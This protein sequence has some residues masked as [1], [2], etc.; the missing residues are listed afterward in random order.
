MPVPTWKHK[1][2][3]Y[4]EVCS[5]GG[6][7]DH[8]VQPP[9]LKKGHPEPVAQD[10]VQAGWEWSSLT[11]E[12]VISLLATRDGGWTM[13]PDPGGKEDHS[14]E[15]CAQL[16]R[17]HSSRLLFLKQLACCLLQPPAQLQSRIQ[18]GAAVLPLGNPAR[19][20]PG[21]DVSRSRTHGLKGKSR[22]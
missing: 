3:R 17:S 15:L 8:L 2:Q 12:K 6:S 5:Y 16:V 11:S 21:A 4:E 10:N 9:P 1:T 13:H 22:I 7:G 19:L 20:F 18:P 14:A